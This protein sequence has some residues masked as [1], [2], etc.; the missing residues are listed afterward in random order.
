MENKLKPSNPGNAGHPANAIEQL[1]GGCVEASVK[2]GGTPQEVAGRAVACSLLKIAEAAF[3]PD[4][5]E[6]G[7]A[8]PTSLNP[9]SA[10]PKEP[11]KR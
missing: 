8:N 6:P 2:L 10:E 5:P 3:R 9:A 7:R 1:V 11:A 4:P